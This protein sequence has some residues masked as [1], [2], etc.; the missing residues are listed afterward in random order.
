MDTSIKRA[1]AACGGI[2]E[3]ARRVG[4]ARAY[5]WQMTHGVRPVPATLVLLIEAATDGQVT[6][7]ELR[8]DVFGDPP[9]QAA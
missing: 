1:A 8:P 2:P 5:V 7:Y 4:K 3:L 9:S 6:R